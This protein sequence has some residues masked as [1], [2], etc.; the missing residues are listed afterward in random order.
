MVDGIRRFFVEVGIGQFLVEM[1][2]LFFEYFDFLGQFLEFELL[3]V[4]E[5]GNACGFI[6]FARCFCCF[7]GGWFGG[8][9]WFSLGDPVV[10]AAGVFFDEAV[11]F[12]DEGSG[13]DVVDEFAVVTDEQ[14]G[15]VVVE[16]EFFEEFKSFEVEIV[17]GFVEEEDIGGLGEHFGQEESVSFAAGEAPDGGAGESG[18]EE[19]VLEVA[20]DVA[21]FAVDE[22]GLGAGA[23][24]FGGGFLFVKF[25]VELIKVGDLEVG[26]VGDRTGLGGELV[27]EEAH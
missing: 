2:E 19:E 18:G 24:V 15:A 6:F 27:E 20:E 1:G 3:G 12:E 4:G 5:A 8:G 17:G 10:V 23:D 14:D 7:F 22:D 16:E 26:A 25:G 21:G 9:F 11:A 13:G